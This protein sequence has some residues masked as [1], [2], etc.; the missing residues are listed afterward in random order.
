MAG[1]NIYHFSV[2]NIKHL[3][4][5]LFIPQTNRSNE[6]N[7]DQVRALVAA[8]FPKAQSSP[9]AQLFQSVTASDA[10][11]NAIEF[12][13]LQAKATQAAIKRAAYNHAVDCIAVC[14]SQ[15]I[16]Y[17]AET[18]SFN[19]ECNFPE[20]SVDDCDDA[21]EKALNKQPGANE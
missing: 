18:L 13:Q 7:A 21:A 20:L 2:D 17:D 6:M 5:T 8:K 3:C 10:A 9:L 1:E 12:A 16:D 15:G 11:D 19:V 4:D 14:E